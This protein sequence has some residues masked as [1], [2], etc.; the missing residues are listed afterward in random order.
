VTGKGLCSIKIGMKPNE[1]PNS[2]AP[3]DPGSQRL[4]VACTQSTC[5][6]YHALDG[7]ERGVYCECSHTQKAYFL[8]VK[9]CPLFRMNW[10]Q[11]NSAGADK[12]KEI[13]RSKRKF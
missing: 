4:R 5:A 6:Y 11:V 8:N 2:G 3:E 9:P 1:R 10:I 13:I 12:A 7:P